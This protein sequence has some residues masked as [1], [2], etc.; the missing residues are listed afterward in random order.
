[1]ANEADAEKQDWQELSRLTQGQPLTIQRIRL[2]GTKIAIEG[3][4]ELP[5]LAQLSSEDQI[6]VMGFLQCQGSIKDMERLFGVSY[7]TIKS[8]LGR[9]NQ[10]LGFVEV[11][12][13]VSKSDILLQ[14]E[15]G[16]IS[17]AEALERLKK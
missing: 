14:L 7:P 11:N 3:N 5:R 12:P 16:E 8:R 6:F 9:I 17:T 2:S 13:P 1:M 4:F 15:R 10:A